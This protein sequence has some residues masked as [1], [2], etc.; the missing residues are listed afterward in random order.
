MTPYKPDCNSSNCLG[1]KK[2]SKLTSCGTGDEGYTS[3]TDNGTKVEIIS[4]EV[5]GATLLSGT[6]T[7]E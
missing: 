2:G 4:C 3:V 5:S 1:L 6:V 7:I